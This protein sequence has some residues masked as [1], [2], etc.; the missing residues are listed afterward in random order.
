MEFRGSALATF[1]TGKRGLIFCNA[2]NLSTLRFDRKGEGVPSVDRSSGVTGYR[3]INGSL[4]VFLNRSRCRV[5]VFDKSPKNKFYLIKANGHVD[6]EK[7]RGIYS[8]KIESNVPIKATFHMRETCRLKAGKKL[9]VEIGREVVRV[10]S[11]GK[12]GVFK[13][14]CSN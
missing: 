13:V 14:Y 12:T 3:K 1:N 7:G 11:E 9:K 8:V 5:V 6:M 10:S 4:Y 2:G